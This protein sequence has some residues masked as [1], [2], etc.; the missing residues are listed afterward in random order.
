MITSLS[1]ARL[2]CKLVQRASGNTGNVFLKEGRQATTWCWNT[3]RQ[4]KLRSTT[5]ALQNA[6]VPER[7]H[8]KSPNSNQDGFHLSALLPA[9][10]GRQR[11]A[12]ESPLMEWSSTS[13][14]SWWSPILASQRLGEA[15]KHS[16]SQHNS[17]SHLRYTRARSARDSHRANATK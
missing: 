6:Q 8:R 3:G 2:A 10:G 12:G 5:S 11:G 7:W 16:S 1:N 9:R 13:R 15:N 17:F 14:L 4:N